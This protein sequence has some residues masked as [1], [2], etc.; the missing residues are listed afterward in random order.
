MKSEH[1]EYNR[2]RRSDIKFLSRK[3]EPGIKTNLQYR[4]RIERKDPVVRPLYKEAHGQRN[5]VTS[6]TV[7]KANSERRQN[8]LRNLI[9]KKQ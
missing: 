7:A 9:L 3:D 5:R 4:F 1:D 6:S 2:H 8:V